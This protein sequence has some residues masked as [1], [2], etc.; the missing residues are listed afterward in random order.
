MKF[1]E[2]V[3]ETR[4]WLQRDGWLSHRSLRM[5][6][7]LNDEQFDVLKEQ[8]IDTEELAADKDRKCSPS[9]IMRQVARFR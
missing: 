8:L 4:E 7:D 2:V 3:K 5:E 9:A 1:S 6:F